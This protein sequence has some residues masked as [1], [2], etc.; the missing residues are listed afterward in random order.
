MATP[1]ETGLT[2][3]LNERHILVYAQEP[4]LLSWQ[5]HAQQTCTSCMTTYQCPNSSVIP[6]QECPQ[7]HITSTP[8]QLPYMHDVQQ[9]LS[10]S[11][12][13]TMNR[14]ML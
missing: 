9:Q 12:Q 14:M 8:G 7:P 4:S 5:D 2:A 10:P 6:N 13:E 1:Q 11:N 3:P